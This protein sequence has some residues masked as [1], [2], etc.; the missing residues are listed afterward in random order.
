M[1]ALRFYAPQDVRLED[2]PEPQCGP[3]EVKLRVR[4]CSTCGT[5]VKIFNNGHQNISPPRTM[6]HEIAGEVVEVGAN[7]GGWS[8]GD[9]AQVI[10]AVPCGECYEC[11]KGWMAVC[12][13]QTSVGYQYEGGFAEYLIVP[14]Q[15]LKVDGLNR[16]PDNIGFDEASVAEPF[17]CAINAQELISVG[18]GDTVVV[19]GAGPIGCIHIRLARANG[20]ERVFLIDVNADR[21]KMSADAVQPDEVINGSEVDVVERVKELTGGRGA[22]VV[23]TAT[24]ANI[25]Q[26]QAIG[27]AARRGRISFFGGLP[28]TNP[29]IK[30]D[31]NLV[32][33]REL[34][35]MGANGSAPEH[36]KR[37]LE[38]IST[39]KVPVKDLITARLPLERALEA[40]DIVAKGEAI[41]V[42]IE[43]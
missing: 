23:I 19:F 8:V 41:K 27:M 40:F 38:Y 9:R 29:F 11:R 6:G 32:H 7:V 34:M 24:A 42:T 20:A 16:I 3:D 25:A 43:P 18:A 37:A 39:G 21:L 10:A 36:N 12:E 30:C 4:N 13:N 5:D 26:E 33:Y 17:A 22:D 28:K 1:Q 2:V 35:I 15:V 31:S 14:R